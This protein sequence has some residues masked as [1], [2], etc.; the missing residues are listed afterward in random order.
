MAIILALAQVFDLF[1]K[2][3]VLLQNFAARGLEVMDLFY[4]L[5]LRVAFADFPSDVFRNQL[6]I[7]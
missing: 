4:L 3:C 5:E 6:C 2:F 1:L 7:W